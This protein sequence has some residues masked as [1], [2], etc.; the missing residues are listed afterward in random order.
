MNGR[1]VFTH[2][3]SFALKPSGVSTRVGSVGSGFIPRKNTTKQHLIK[4]CDLLDQACA[5]QG[6]FCFIQYPHFHVALA[7]DGKSLHWDY[8]FTVSRGDQ[9]VIIRGY[10]PFTYHLRGDFDDCRK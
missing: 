4:G 3:F 9:T 2:S 8:C 5:S 1:P 10:F 7:P 6:R